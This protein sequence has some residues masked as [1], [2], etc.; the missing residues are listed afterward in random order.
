MTDRSPIP[1]QEPGLLARKAESLRLRLRALLGLGAL[2]N[3]IV[4][5]AMKSGTTSLFDYLTQHPD[6][7]GSRIKELHYFDNNHRLG[8]RWYRA[9]FA[10]RGERVL[11]ESSPY[12][13]FHPLAPARAA[14]LVPDAKL[15]LLLRNPVDRAYSHYN[16]NSEE[17]LE[18]LSFE[19]ALE[20]EAERLAGQ[21]EALASGAVERS[22]AHQTFSYAAKGHYAPQL[23]RWL[24]HFPREQL[25]ILKAEDLF[26]SPQESVD[27]V[28]DFL[29]IARFTIA[30]LSGGN[31]RR[32][33]LMHPETR[34]RLE[35]MF[36]DQ[37]DEVRALTG[38]E[39]PRRSADAPLAPAEIDLQSP[40]LLRSPWDGYDAVRTHGDA[41]WLPRQGFW[42][43]VGHGAVREGLG[44]PDLYSNAPY[45]ELDPVLA[46]ADPPRHGSARALVE[47]LL[48]PEAAEHAANAS[49]GEAARCLQP[50]FDAVGGFAQPIAA[51]AMS[52]LLG[53]PADTLPVDPFSPAFTQA[54]ANAQ[55][56]QRWVTDGLRPEGAASLFRLVWLAGTVA[57]ERTLAWSVYELLGDAELDARLSAE[58]ALLPGFTEEIIRLHPPTHML[59]RT[60]TAAT[61]LAGACI[62]EGADLRLCLAAANRDPA[63]FE[64]PHCIDLGRTRGLHLGFGAGP[65]ACAGAALARLMLPGLVK[66]LLDWGFEAAAPLGDVRFEQAVETLA[67]TFLPIRKRQS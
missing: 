43:V 59:N 29:G 63:V 34:R 39:W 53:M 20:R 52:A 33:P 22:H 15:I 62:P 57:L 4:I 30:D 66:T 49:A 42:L 41:V 58:P 23:R 13:F 38:L 25:L 47:A 46:G 26:R 17:G 24:E 9:N 31:R 48:S 14:A 55:A 61:A 28:T 54:A 60:A 36:A 40:H 32:Y 65:H 1:P 50:E 11:L 5:G 56:H 10:P 18:P 19:D 37:A 45:R 8:S 21:E 3:A 51:V 12:Y 16:Q 35:A 27:Q 2:P 64:N 44:R 6:V 7:C 67:P